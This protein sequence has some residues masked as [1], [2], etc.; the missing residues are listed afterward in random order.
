MAVRITPGQQHE[1]TMAQELS[2][3]FSLPGLNCKPAALAGDKGYYAKALICSLYARSIKP[4]IPNHMKKEQSHRFP[5]ELYRRR[6]VVER[7]IGLLKKCRRIAT[8]YEK[9]ALNYLAML[10]IAIIQR[11]L[12]MIDIS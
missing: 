11:L 2:K 1:A 6:N 4:V 8:R 10:K 5:R 9:L 7:A 3:A 12:K